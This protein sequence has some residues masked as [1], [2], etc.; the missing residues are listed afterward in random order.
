MTV[1]TATRI[2]SFT[3]HVFNTGAD[4]FARVA[5]MIELSRQRRA[6]AALDGAALKD[7]GVSHSEAMEEAA[8]PAWDAPVY[9]QS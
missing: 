3:G 7:I 9:W 8:R 5:K 1:L 6:L 4:V 2:D